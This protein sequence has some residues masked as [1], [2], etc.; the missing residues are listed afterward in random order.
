MIVV[1]THANC[2][3]E[4][5]LVGVEHR[6]IYRFCSC[7]GSGLAGRSSGEDRPTCRLQGSSRRSGRFPALPYPPLEQMGCSPPSLS[8]FRGVF[9]V[10]VSLGVHR[11]GKGNG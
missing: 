7:T 3:C 6:W 1:A 8:A 2:D 10:S 9:P 11:R 4:L 5:N